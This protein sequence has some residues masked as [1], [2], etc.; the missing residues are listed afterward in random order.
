MRAEQELQ[1]DAGPEAEQAVGHEVGVG[2]LAPGRGREGAEP[3]GE[4]RADVGREPVAG[5]PQPADR[6]EALRERREELALRGPVVE[7]HLREPAGEGHR[8]GDVAL[9]PRA[10]EAGDHGG[11]ELRE[12][13]VDQIGLGGEVDV[14]RAVRH[15]GAAGDVRDLCRAV[16]LLGEALEGR[17]LEEGAGLRLLVDA[18][19]AFR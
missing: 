15:A 13:V 7:A 17:L 1:A 19:A 5:D 10:L 2:E 16:T 11:L 18:G 14:E 3:V 8:V 9:A 4:E 6:A 12:Q